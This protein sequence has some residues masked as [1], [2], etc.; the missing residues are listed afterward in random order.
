MLRASS[1]SSVTGRVDDAFKQHHDPDD[2]VPLTREIALSAGAGRNC[3]RLLRGAP[4][5][6]L[7]Q[8]NFVAKYGIGD[9]YENG[10]TLYHQDFPGHAI[11]RSE[12]AT[13]WIALNEVTPEMGSLRFVGAGAAPPGEPEK[14]IGCCLG[15]FGSGMER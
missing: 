9:E 15:F 14:I 10:A 8:R 11:D 6:R 3:A 4:R 5:A 12:M 13:V 7:L 1:Y 2:E